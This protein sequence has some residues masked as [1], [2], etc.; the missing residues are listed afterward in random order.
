[1]RDDVAEKRSF[2]HE[3]VSY[4]VDENDG[5]RGKTERAYMTGGWDWHDI[6]WEC[7][8]YPACIET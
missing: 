6:F 2:G 8:R 7:A 3:Q 1:M 5:W 4:G